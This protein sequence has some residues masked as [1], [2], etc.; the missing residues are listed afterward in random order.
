MAKNKNK[1]YTAK[2]LAAHAMSRRAFARAKEILAAKGCSVQ[3]SLRA[4]W[5]EVKGVKAAANPRGGSDDD[6]LLQAIHQDKAAAILPWEISAVRKLAKSGLVE[7]LEERKNLIRYAAT[8]KGRAAAGKVPR[9]YAPAAQEF[10]AEAPISLSP[11][12]VVRGTAASGRRTMPLFIENR[13][14]KHNP[15]HVT[16]KGTAFYLKQGE[17]GDPDTHGAQKARRILRS[18]GVDQPLAGYNIRKVG[19]Q[20]KIIAPD[21]SDTGKYGLSEDAAERLLAKHSRASR[22]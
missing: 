19:N 13:R 18:E 8:P 10:F 20:Y 22:R 6:L 5:S 17:I 4:A 11:T 9:F 1:K 2:Q 12:N 15:Y 7:I 21:G 14:K 3:D 16:P